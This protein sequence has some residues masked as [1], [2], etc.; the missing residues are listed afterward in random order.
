MQLTKFS[1]YA[2]RV[3]MFAA[4]AGDRLVTIDETARI[5]GISRAHLMKVVTALT[6]AGYLES[7]RGR[8]GGFRLARPPE[9]IPLGEVLRLTEP[10][11][12]LV[13]CFKDSSRCV[14]APCCRL[15]GVIDEA[16]TAFLAV[17]DRCTLA[18][19]ALRPAD[20]PGAFAPKDDRPAEAPPPA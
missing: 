13:E 16:L 6:R 8:S 19:V 10:D 2:L 3:L 11:F 9:E 15:P 20:F 7:V 18:D 14:V 4:A 5:Y 12:A 17:F 1:D